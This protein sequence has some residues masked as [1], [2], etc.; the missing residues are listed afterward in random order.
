MS[1][2]LHW[3]FNEYKRNENDGKEVSIDVL[4]APVTLSGIE[5]NTL[6][7]LKGHLVLD[8]TKTKMGE[9]DDFQE[10]YNIIFSVD[11]KVIGSLYVVT[12]YQQP[13]S[14]G[15]QTFL[16]NITGTVSCKG[17]FSDFNNGTA[18]IQ[19]DNKSGKRCLSLYENNSKITSNP[20]PSPEPLPQLAGDWTYGGSILRRSNTNEKPDFD[21]IITIPPTNVK[22]TQ[23][24]RYII[25]EIPTDITRPIPGFLLGCLT[26]VV[27]HW[28]LTFSDYD[29][30][31]IFSLNEIRK[32]VWEGAY[33]ESG[34]CGSR[35]Q[36]QTT[37]I[38]RL[39]KR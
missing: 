14:D 8:I 29:D 21:N 32:G 6:T 15:F 26:Y 10:N 3:N 23:K 25:V 37:G 28:K 22:I 9:V 39:E 31:G 1:C 36:F 2:Q 5:N 38:I 34:F 27:N 20:Q 35:E 17:L 33:Q 24:E 16:N 7:D 18:I 13:Q 11:S 4:T 12:G 19:F 30:N